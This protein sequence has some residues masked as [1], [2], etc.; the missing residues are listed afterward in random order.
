MCLSLF[1]LVSFSDR[2]CQFV[3]PTQVGL[4]LQKWAG[5]R[6]HS[7]GLG[8][9]RENCAA[10]PFLATAQIQACRDDA[11]SA[12]EKVTDH[13]RHVLRNDRQRCN[14]LCGQSGRE[15]AIRPLSAVLTRAEGEGGG[16]R[17]SGGRGT[18]VHECTVQSLL[19]YVTGW[20]TL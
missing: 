11:F 3:G 15:K 20:R 8:L 17:A 19:A 9:H 10:P 18:R 16:R 5:P 6:A 1:V 12:E 13:A 2:I 4:R 14:F 7:S